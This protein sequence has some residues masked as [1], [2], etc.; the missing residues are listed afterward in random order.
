M[1]SGIFNNRNVE[2]ILLFL[3]VNEKG[4]GAQIQLLLKVPLTPIQRALNRLEKEGIVTSYY[5]G[6]TRLYE[7][8]S[9]YPLRH[10]LEL[11]LKKGY[12]LLP[13]HE[14][15]RYCFIH[16]PRLSLGNER[17]RD[18][19][20]KEELLAF[21]Q[22]LASVQTLSFSAKL[23]QMETSSVKVGK[24]DVV[25]E[26]PT[27]SVLIFRETGYWFNHQ[28]P[29]TAFSNVFR[30]TL[31]LDASLIMLEHLRYGMTHPVFL[32]HLTPTNPGILESVDAH[33]CGEDTYLGN[34][35]WNARNLSFNWRIV[36][37]R[38]NDHLIYH[39]S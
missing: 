4:Y 24:A 15:R 39:Y 1:L 14:K 33:L 32:F 16:K 7:L 30:W 19:N 8:S 36:G 9:T 26:S 11:L 34:I 23:R 29:E 35:S 17:K 3:F 25:I 12:T 22:R 27:S 6:K 10:E 31:D 38:K 13:A 28:A 37:P 18:R 2:R 21:W 5:E 20:R